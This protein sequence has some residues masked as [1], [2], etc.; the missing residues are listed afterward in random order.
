MTQRLA[1]SPIT[2]GLVFLGSM[3]AAFMVT[4]SATLPLLAAGLPALHGALTA[5]SAL[6]AASNPPT[7]ARNTTLELGCAWGLGLAFVVTLIGRDNVLA[8]LV[9]W[10]MAA[11]ATLILVIA[12]ALDF[13]QQRQHPELCRATKTRLMLQICA[14]VVYSLLALWMAAVAGL[15]LLVWLSGEPYMGN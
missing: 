10:P 12:T 8:W 5:K 14:L 2:M 6:Q 7:H 11:I 4:K 9:G 15:W 13:R 3:A 1:N